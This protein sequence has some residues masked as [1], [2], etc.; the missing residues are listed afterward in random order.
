MALRNLFAED[1]RAVETPFL[2]RVANHYR[3]G[4]FLQIHR[5]ERTPVFAVSRGRLL[6]AESTIYRQE[7]QI[8]E[9]VRDFHSR[10]RLE[11]VTGPAGDRLKF[12][13]LVRLGKVRV[14]PFDY[15]G[16]VTML[17]FGDIVEE[18]R[19]EFLGRAI[20]V[21]QDQN[22]GDMVGVIGDVLR[23]HRGMYVSALSLAAQYCR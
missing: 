3:R 10:R 21:D 8:G 14:R 23:R 6:I 1:R 12:L 7:P 4:E 5:L 13:R 15:C 20:W 2:D 9:L 22:D 19:F 11:L 17:E 16:Y 18:R